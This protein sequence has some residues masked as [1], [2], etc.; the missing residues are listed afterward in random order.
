MT[1]AIR[2]TAWPAAQPADAGRG[3]REVGHPEPQALHPQQCNVEQ[4]GGRRGQR[5]EPVLPLA[6][7]VHDPLDGPDRRE[8]AVSLESDVLCLDVGSGQVGGVGKVQR[9]LDRAGAGLTLEL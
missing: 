4:C 3:D 8:A 1:G 5:A 7:H 9:E 6:P 2:A